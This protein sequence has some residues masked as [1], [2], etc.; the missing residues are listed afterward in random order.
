MKIISSY[1]DPETGKSTVEIIHKKRI[2]KGTAYLHPEDN[3][4]ASK[5]TGCFY[6]HIRAEIKAL[7]Y[8]YKKEKELCEACRNFIKSCEQYNNFDKN[9]K[10]AKVM[11]RQINRR[12]KTV[13]KIAD[14]INKRIELL[15][16]K[17]KNIK[18]VRDALKRK[19]EKENV[20]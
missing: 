9:D 20:Q 5:Y 4:Y 3:D 6:A 17:D 15:Y 10:T 12:I 7:K 19:K 14:E 11:Y 18:I 8:E 1:F 13:N 16:T 2:Y